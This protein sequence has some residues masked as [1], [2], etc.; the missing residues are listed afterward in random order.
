[1][2]IETTAIAQAAQTLAKPIKPRRA[3]GAGRSVKPQGA[4]VK[5]TWDQIPAL[6]KTAT[7]KDD[8]SVASWVTLTDRL[9][10]LGVRP[11]DFEVED[12]DAKGLN[13]FNEVYRKVHG[14]VVGSYTD[15]AQALLRAPTLALGPDQRTAKEI[16]TGRLTRHLNTILKYLKKLD[17]QDR[18]AATQTTLAAS[19][20]K[21]LR[22]MKD[23]IKR[24]KES[25]ITF[26]VTDVLTCIDDVIDHLT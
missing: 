23:R 10:V 21:A 8:E 26:K 14:L 12:E 15:K 22:E 13:R 1:M 11:S 19:L 2:A 4:A 24:A 25:R 16:E 17:A 7:K 5:V 3:P 18:G 6:M 20:I 9:W